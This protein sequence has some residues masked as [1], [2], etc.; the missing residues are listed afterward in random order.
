MIQTIIIDDEADARESLSMALKTYCS[1]IH[2]LAECSSAI[3]GLQRIQEHK[4]ELVFLDIQM[5][6][7]TGFE[8]L[9]QLETI[10]FS[11]IFVTAY[12]TYAIKAIKFSA[13]DY[14]LK[15]LDIDDL[16]ESVQR[17]V[18]EKK[19]EADPRYKHLFNNLNPKSPQ[20][21]ERLAIS[22]SEGMEFIQV[23]DIIYCQASGNY[24]VVHLPNKQHLLVSKT[25]K[26]FELLLEDK[27]FCRVHHASLINLKHIQ[28][29]IKGEGGY[30]LLNDGHSVDISRRR[31]EE[32]LK[33]IAIL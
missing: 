16:Q 2:V 9:Q 1:E 25:L 24:T 22:T 19:E 17:L 11:T 20:P 27:G 3:E 13:F 21:F 4:P 28:K 5:P 29:Y 32:F 30:V 33:R 23:E 12:D 15:P 31:K 18:E 10:D 14:L 7:M 8:M 26:D 6:H